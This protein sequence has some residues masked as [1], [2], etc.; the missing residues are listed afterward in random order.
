MHSAMCVGEK[1]GGENAMK[2]RQ[3]LMQSDKNVRK[4]ELQKIENDP[5]VTNVGK[6]IRRTSMD[7]LPNLFSVLI[8]DM[9]LVGPRPHMELEI[10]KYKAWHK[11]LLSVKPGIT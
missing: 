11:R 7:E 3:E 6:F 10:A 4:G 5:R 9:S 2:M 1:Y 8:G